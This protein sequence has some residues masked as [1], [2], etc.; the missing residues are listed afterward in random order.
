M[1]AVQSKLIRCFSLTFPFLPTESITRCSAQTV[2]Q[3]DSVAQIT[4]LTLIAEEFEIEIDFE[5]FENALSFETLA[6]RLRERDSS[7]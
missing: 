5:E 4:L 3:W 6:N 7:V 1:D 2:A